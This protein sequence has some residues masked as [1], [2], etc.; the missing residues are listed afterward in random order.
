[1]RY[2]S[3]SILRKAFGGIA[4]YYWHSRLNFGEVDLRL[5]DYKS[6]SATRTTSPGHRTAEK[7]DALLI[8]LCTK[9]EQRLVKAEIYCRQATLFFRYTNLT[10]WDT[11]IRLT[12]PLQDAMELRAHLMSRVLEFQHARKCS[13]LLN[14]DIKQMGVTVTDFQHEDQLQ[15]SLF[16]PYRMEQDKLRKVMYNIK[17]KWGKYAVC[18]AS[19]LVEKS[20]MQDA[21]GFGSVR[22]LYEGY[23]EINKFLLEE[24]DE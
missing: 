12:E 5:N 1:M 13:P 2:T 18:K 17:D 3:Q 14:G 10:G 16:D 8:S 7:M 9:L 23:G 19:E 24:T 22:D 21:I 11:S 4:G 15:Y 20:M 6:M